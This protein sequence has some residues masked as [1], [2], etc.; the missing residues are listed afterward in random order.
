MHIKVK[1][2]RK[3]KSRKTQKFLLRFLQKANGRGRSPREKSE[4]KR[5][6]TIDK[7]TKCRHKKKK[8]KRK[9]VK[10]AKHSKTGI[11]VCGLFSSR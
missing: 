7:G 8:A 6:I 1:Y 4:T 10:N 9:Y 3:L 2:K 11:F 5:E